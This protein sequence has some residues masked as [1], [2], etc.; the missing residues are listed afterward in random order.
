MG[1]GNPLTMKTF[2]QSSFGLHVNGSPMG[3]GRSGVDF[4]YRIPKLRNWLSLYGEGFSETKFRRSTLR[5]SRFGRGGCISLS[6]LE[7]P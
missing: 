3:D 6:C 7:I 4:S 2:F 1:T 5:R